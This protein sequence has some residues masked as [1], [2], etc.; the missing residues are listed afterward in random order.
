MLLLLSF[1]IIG[2]FTLVRQL[3]CV[4]SQIKKRNRQAVRRE[5]AR[6]L[7]E[8]RGASAWKSLSNHA[9]PHQPLDNRLPRADDVLQSVLDAAPVDGL[10]LDSIIWEQIDKNMADFKWAEEDDYEDLIDTLTQS[11]QLRKEL[12]DWS[13]SHNISKKSLT[14]LLKILQSKSVTLALY[15]ARSVCDKAVEISEL[16]LDKKIDILALTETWLKKEN[17]SV[18]VDICP[19]NF[20]FVGQHR[21][22]E[23][24]YRREGVG[25]VIS[26]RFSIKQH[27]LKNSPTTFESQIITIKKKTPDTA[28][29]DHF[30]VTAKMKL[31]Q[32]H[33][34][35][36]VLHNCRNFHSINMDAFCRDLQREIGSVVQI[37]DL[38]E[39][40]KGYNDGIKNVLDIHAPL[41]SI[42]LKE[43]NP[44]MWYD[45]EI[46]EARR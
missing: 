37:Q 44:K 28:F 20:F 19:D 2:S 4:Y 3:P 38:D 32:D 35:K 27:A 31:S 22:N 30:L 6:V 17:G 29:S 43:G 11:E 39:L 34:P 25:F 15:S 9:A 1:N 14:P 42:T 45:A 10:H 23:K 24:G 26:R 13:I 18:I 21:P 7:K 16:I 46:H 33:P 40:I 41:K 5:V 12:A 36:K 8:V